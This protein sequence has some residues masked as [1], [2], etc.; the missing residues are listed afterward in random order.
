M[1]PNKKAALPSKAGT[2]GKAA[3]TQQNIRKNSNICHNDRQADNSA[4]SQRARILQWLLRGSLTT[5]QARGLGIMHP[6]MRI[7]ELRKQGHEIV[8][9]RVD[10]YCPG[11][12]RHRVARYFLRFEEGQP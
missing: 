11:G 1:A 3:L 5:L 4:A 10:E 7:C 12:M 8:T 6:G 2:L 9:E